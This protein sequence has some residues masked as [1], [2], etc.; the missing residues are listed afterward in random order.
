MI[1]FVESIKDRIQGKAPKG[2]KRSS[3]WR[4]VRAA[5]LKQYP[6]CSVCGTSKGIQ[7]HHKKPFHVFPD[8]EL[9]PDNLTSLCEK[10]KHGKSCHLLFGHLGNFR[11]VNDQVDYDIMIW[12]MKLNVFTR[13]SGQDEPHDEGLRPKEVLELNK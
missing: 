3:K 10:V 7:V 11:R 12:R 13:N 4:K 9:D 1:G 2:A 5:H 8:L 6:Y